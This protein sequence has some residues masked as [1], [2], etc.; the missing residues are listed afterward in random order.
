MLS[1]RGFCKY[2]TTILCILVRRVLDGNYVSRLSVGERGF[3][4]ELGTL[5]VLTSRKVM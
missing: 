5:S 4:I 3:G 2:M 1:P